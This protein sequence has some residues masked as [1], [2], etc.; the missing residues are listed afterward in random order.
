MFRALVALSATM[1][2][3]RSQLDVKRS[4]LWLARLKGGLSVEHPIASDE[5]RA[6][7]RYL[8]IREDNLPW[9]FVSERASS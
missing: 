1:Q 4:R 8:A 6:I 2:M 3:R 7:K 9:L 5:L